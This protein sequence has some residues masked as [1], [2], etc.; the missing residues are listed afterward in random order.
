M[1]WF[2]RLGGRWGDSRIMKKKAMER[3]ELIGR[4]REQNYMTFRQIGEKIGVSASRASDLYDQLIRHREDTGNFGHG[5]ATRPRYAM[6]N[7]GIRT[8]EEAGKWVLSGEAL[9]FRNYGKLCDIQL[10]EWLGLP[11]K[12][13]GMPTGFKCPNCGWPHLPT[14]PAESATT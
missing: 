9:K 7:A 1:G 5:L 11:P 6:W 4:F 12:P 10:R 13:K 8:K 14:S 3:L 2:N